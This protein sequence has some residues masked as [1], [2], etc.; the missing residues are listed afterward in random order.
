MTWHTL[1]TMRIVETIVVVYV[2][3]AILKYALWGLGIWLAMPFAILWRMMCFVGRFLREPQK[4][5]EWV[6][7]ER[8]R[9]AVHRDVRRRI[10]ARKRERLQ[11]ARQ[12]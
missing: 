5:P 3:L 7:S 8:E 12:H 1:R 11:H 6:R 4:L 9:V 10:V 2:F